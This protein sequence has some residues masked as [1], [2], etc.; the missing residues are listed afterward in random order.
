MKIPRDNG[1]PRA[2]RG[3]AANAATTKQQVLE[4]RSASTTNAM[5]IGRAIR[6]RQSPPAKHQ[7]D[8]VPCCDRC[9][10]V[11]RHRPFDGLMTYERAL[12]CRPSVIYVITVVRIVPDAVVVVK[13]IPETV[14]GVAPARAVAS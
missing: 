7:L 5:L 3:P 14:R 1:G 2:T 9:R 11:H 6:Y 13:A 12:P 4:D 10:R 8:V